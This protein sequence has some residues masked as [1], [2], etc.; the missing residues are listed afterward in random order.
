MVMKSGMRLWLTCCL[1]LWGGSMLA[2]ADDYCYLKVN[3]DPEE[4]AFVSGNGKYKVNGSRVLISTSAKNT[5]DYVYTFLYW[6]LDGKKVSTSPSFYYTPTT[7]NHQIVAYYDKQE[8][9]FDPDNPFDPSSSNYK[10]KYY[11]YLASNMEGICSFSIASGNKVEEKTDMNISVL[12][13]SSYYQFEG[14][15]LDGTIISSETSLNFTMPS[16]TTTLEACFSEKNTDPSEIDEPSEPEANDDIEGDVNGD[17]F[18]DEKDLHAI[19][20]HIMGKPQAGNFDVNKA[21]INK[22]GK[23]NAADVVEFIKL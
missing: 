18:L 10:R 11:L 6:T 4:G 23:V 15:K 7:G 16:G 5:E 22:D 14:W 3:A 2:L 13:E 20:N 1:F 12:Y 8:T 9:E 17:G 21:D 19:I